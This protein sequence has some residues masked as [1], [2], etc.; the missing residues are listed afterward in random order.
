[1]SDCS[2]A[3][4]V[5]PVTKCG[6]T[7]GFLKPIRFVPVCS[8][9]ATALAFGQANDVPLRHQTVVPRTGWP[10]Q[11]LSAP[12]PQGSRRIPARAPSR[13][14]QTPQSAEF[15]FANAVTYESGGFV[16]GAVVAADVNG[17]GKPDL[18]VVNVCGSDST[19]LTNGS[20]GVL[21]N[22]GNGTFGPAVAYSSNGWSPNAI[23]VADVNG[24]GKADIVVVNQCRTNSGNCTTDGT[25][26]V[27]L[28]NGDGTFQAAV[29]YDSGG[30]QAVSVAI[31]DVNA[32]GHPDLVVVNQCGSSTF[33]FCASHGTVA[34]LLGNGD[35]TFQ[36]AVTYDTGGFDD[37][38]DADAVAVADLRGDGKLD[39]VVANACG[40][41]GCANGIPPQ[42][43]SVGVLLGNGDGTFQAVTTYPTSAGLTGSVAV[44]DLNGDG[45]LDIAASD[46][47]ATT[48]TNCLG[49]DVG[50]GHIDVFVGNG[51]GTFS[52]V[53]TY[54]TSARDTHGVSIADV[55]GDGIPDFEVVVQCA[56]YSATCSFASSV[57]VLLG[58]GGGTFQ[59][60]QY[61][62]P[63]GN[64]EG[65]ALLGAL[66][67][68]DVDGDGKPDLVLTDTCPVDPNCLT[69]GAVGVLIN[70]STFPNSSPSTTA[71]TSSPNPSN[72]G[73]SVTFTVTVSPSGS[74]S[75]PT[76]TVSLF[77]G[78][79]NL[80]LF[81]LNSSGIATA[82]TATLPSGANSITATYNGD[83]GL[84]P[85]TSA[86]LS[87]AVL[88][89]V[90]SP[91]SLNFA[92]QN[93]GTTS[94]PQAVMLTN[95]EKTPISISSIGITGA[96]SG[97]FVQT[98]NCPAS[99][100]ANGSCTVSVTFTPSSPANFVANLSVSDSLPGSPQV[101]AL[102]GSGF[103]PPVTLS[104]LN[105]TFPDQYVGTS[106]LPQTVTLTNN[107]GSSITI[108]KVSTT[109]ADFG[110]LNTCG[111]TVASG[112]S[113]SIGVFFDP[114]QGG[115]RSGVL[116]ISTSPTGPLTETLTGTGQDFSL[117]SSS[118]TATV[119]PGQ[120]AT[121]K[122]GVSPLGGFNQTVS[123]SCSGAP[124]Q[125]TCSLSSNSVTLNG[126]APASV[127][128]SVTTPGNSAV[129]APPG[130]S[131]NSRALL[132]C[133]ALFGLPGLLVLRRS[134]PRGP[135]RRKR[136]VSLLGMC[137]L[138]LGLWSLGCGGV[139]AMAEVEEHRPRP[140]I[141]R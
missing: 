22:N 134:M 80:G 125:S 102:S 39:L 140:T 49:S 66:A 132:L 85:S 47:C 99:L 61:F 107:S 8:L 120:T 137:V 97:N 95:T 119:M 3:C 104:P 21:L 42:P 83:A 54:D 36:P 108:S 78:S 84:T 9:L 67:V 126:S 111:S 68:A 76:G 70:T 135:K 122:V 112:S 30:F 124:A 45:K 46:D 72:I 130:A 105:I 115:S 90:F 106:G 103:I 63:I 15:S 139:A 10:A 121:Y 1:M 96:N 16:A 89:F 118:S 100:P 109:T 81:A 34:V 51:D 6:I 62:G 53:S 14:S 59:A 128:V 58:N 129:L 75:T 33:G 56:P 25:V 74:S 127:T 110:S 64:V 133:M 86:A 55:N 71:L 77:D 88:G 117:T 4:R 141:F 116:T 13:K 69:D 19:C 44:A 31:A 114:T 52:L 23:A 101:V 28:G 11:F 138:A 32:D 7:E 136:F 60:P 92:T 113:C 93:V 43:G 35:G 65:T 48:P 131:P 20:V 123:L 79:T 87:Q 94:G 5:S 2:A 91:T 12:T 37:G 27:L 82:A 73:Q 38:V 57:G 18:V 98:N 17:D 26:A 29:N 50:V 24:D 41:P 40:P